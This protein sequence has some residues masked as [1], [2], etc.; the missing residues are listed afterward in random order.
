[1]PSPI[2]L[3]ETSVAARFDHAM[4]E[5]IAT[6]GVIC[7]SIAVMHGGRLAL[8]AGYG[9]GANGRVPIWSLSHEARA[10]GAWIQMAQS[11]GGDLSCS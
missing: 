9:G 8:A 6:H 2:P 3:A 4:R 10:V 11:H 1:M 7:A 5:W